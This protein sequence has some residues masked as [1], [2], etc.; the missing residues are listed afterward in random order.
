MNLAQS[1]IAALAAGALQFAA[2]AG[3]AAEPVPLQASYPVVV[4][5][6]LAA[7]RDFYVRW[8]GYQVVFEATWFVYLASGHHGI[9]FMTPDHPSRP[10]GPE[11]FRG[12]GLFLTLQVADAGAL[13]GRLK[14]A[15]VAIAY[16]LRDEAWGQRRFGLVDP[17][18][19]WVDVVQQIEPAPGYWD[20][21]LP[22]ARRSAKP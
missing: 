2:P 10:P 5:D 19:M 7:C 3:A 4:T 16:P 8:L 17:S 20:K 15:G 11:T 21:Y 18:G 6:R 14:Q 12:K 9:A 13:F 22:A 1:L